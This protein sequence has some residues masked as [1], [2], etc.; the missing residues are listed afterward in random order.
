[1][2][3]S[4]PFFCD[5][6]GAA[7]RPQAAFCYVCGQPL[8]SHAGKSSS[9]TTGLLAYNHLLKQRYRIISQVGKGGFGAVYKAADL[10]FGNRQ[11]AIKEMSQSSLSQQELI[12]ATE[13]FKRE[14]LLLAGLT[15]PNL[16]RIYEQFTDVG[17]WYLVMDFIEGETLE[18]YLGKLPGSKLPVERV[19]EIGIQLC[20][21][22]EYLHMRQP[23]II[24]RDL[25]PSNVMVTSHG[26]IYLIDFGI[27]RHFKPGQAKD[28]T[29]L[30]STGYAAP[31]QYGKAQ[32]TP[33]ADIYALGATLHQ[34][35][36]GNDPADS[37]FQFP[38]LQLSHHPTLSRLE[39]LIMQMIE[40]DAGKRP[41]SI[42]VVKQ[43]LQSISTQELVNRTNPLQAGL[44]HGYRP[45]VKPQ[46]LNRSH[47]ARPQPQKTTRYICSGHS[48]RVT[49][50][51]WSPAGTHLATASFDKTVRIWDTAH[52]FSTI[53]YRGHWDRVQSVT[54][55]PEG[56]RVA[57]AS[58]DGTVQVWDATT[59]KQVLIYRGHGNAVTALAWSPDGR[60]IASAS[61]DKSVQVWDT[62]NGVLIFANR[63]HTKKV[64][65]VAWSPDGRRIA[66]GGEDK[67][68]QV[69]S[70]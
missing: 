37:P 70:P 65:A 4:S 36:S 66:S 55:S 13:S 59:G 69:W 16:P 31:E 19:L 44:P 1:M 35:L 14:A 18:E 46:L 10:Q 34:L 8:Q 67:S 50:V 21:V 12:E 54:W 27:A 68:V 43:Q 62:S 24:F 40:M 5:S 45:P 57:S 51:A 48:S 52:G 58:D 20:M 7:N 30:G 3:I 38:S 15:H 28:T 53:T 25:K 32:T 22:L 64:L 6:C 39:I 42:T 33:R 17:R 29:A 61:N 49:S 26:H 63:T 60:R 11:V 9:Q 56:K 41:A 23:P 47:A 2:A